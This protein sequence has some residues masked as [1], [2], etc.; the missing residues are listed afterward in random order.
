VSVSV[1]LDALDC[2]WRIHALPGEVPEASRFTVLRRCLPRFSALFARFDIKATFFVVG[3]DLERDGE[4]RARLAELCRAG[5][6]LGSHSHAHPYDLVRLSPARIAEEIDRAHDAIASACGVTPVGFRAPGYEVSAHVLD[7][8]CARGYRYDSS[9]FPSVPYYLAKAAVMTAM[10]A[11]GRR[12]NSILG[13]PWALTAPRLPYRPHASSPHARGN[14]PLLELP[15]TVT[16]HL[17]LPVI[18]TALITAPAVLRRH[19]VASALGSPFFNFEL[20]GID[21][22]GA[23]EDALPPA[24]VARQPDLRVPLAKKL[25]ALEETLATAKAVASRVVPLR[26]AALSFTR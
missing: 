8:L 7:V 25:A 1:D 18:G 24:L 5:H 20:H 17:R 9:V 3:Q 14:L 21:L 11:A 4:G 16:R 26:D 6:E 15:V 19:L 10:R 22:A 12:S 13:S 2:Y 23:S